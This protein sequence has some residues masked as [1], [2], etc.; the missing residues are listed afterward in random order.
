MRRRALVFTLALLTATLLAAQTIPPELVGDY[1]AD[2]PGP[3]VTKATIAEYADHNPWSSPD[4]TGVFYLTGT[5]DFVFCESDTLLNVV[6]VRYDTFA[7]RKCYIE[8]PP[9]FGCNGCPTE[10]YEVCEVYNPKPFGPITTSI[11]WNPQ[12][13][14]YIDIFTMWEQTEPIYFVALAL[15]LEGEGAPYATLHEGT[16]VLDGDGNYQINAVIAKGYTTYT[17]MYIDLFDGEFTY[18]E[19][20][21]K[22]QRRH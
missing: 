18:P 3:H 15:V 13:Q 22:V 20:M 21:R 7:T 6:K 8:D 19:R 5:T 2:V 12:Y 17:M 16:F 10:P 14:T 1:G 9:P 4:P 11:T